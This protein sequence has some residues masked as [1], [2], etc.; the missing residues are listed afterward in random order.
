MHVLDADNDIDAIDER[1]VR[2]GTT[3][4]VVA[5]TSFLCPAPRRHRR[6]GFAQ[7]W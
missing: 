3:I 5:Q 4:N 6:L 1:G 2:P 7:K